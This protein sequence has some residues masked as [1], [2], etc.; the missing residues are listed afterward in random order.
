MLKL[1]DAEEAELS[2]RAAA[3]GG[4]SIQRLLVE[5]ELERAA[6]ARGDADTAREL[7]DLQTQVLRAWNNLNQLTRYAHQQR[8]L[9][10]RIEEAVRAATRAAVMTETAA[11]W[12]MGLGPVVA[13]AALPPAVEVDEGPEDWLEDLDAGPGDFA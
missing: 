9:P 11:R 7:M 6:P 3:A 2:A 13:E 4:I 1:S 10:E 12:V 8:E 5:R